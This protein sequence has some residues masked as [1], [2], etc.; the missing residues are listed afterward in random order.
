METG[1]FG[2]KEQSVYFLEIVLQQHPQ[3]PP[4]G[5]NDKLEGGQKAGRLLG[6]VV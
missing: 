6:R 2:Y 1:A 3:I 5:R 4:C